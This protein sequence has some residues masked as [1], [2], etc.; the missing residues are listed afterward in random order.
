MPDK[1]VKVLC[2]NSLPANGNAGLKMVMPVL[3]THAIPVPTLLLS[4]IGNMAGYQRFALPFAEL[5]H[6]TLALARDREQP[7]AVYVGYLA[8]DAQA[9]VIAEAI[10]AFRTMIRF[11]LIDPVCGDNGRA[12]VPPAVIESWQ[13]LLPL[14][15]LA[16]PNL[17]EAALL[18]GLQPP[19]D[20][21]DPD[22][23]ISTF[24]QKYPT[25]TT[26]ITGIV[27]GETVTNR[28]IQADDSGPKTFSHRY[29][30]AYFSGTGDT[31]ASLL[32]R[33]HCVENWPLPDAVR[34]AGAV[35]ERLIEQAIAT[36]SGDLLLADR[37]LSNPSII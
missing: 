12:Y 8:D 24:G 20:L 37:F 14:A 16:L 13:T 21:T 11:V 36:G 27:A 17:T 10:R 22:L 23:I 34:Q 4:G 26:V 32:I 1:S 25:L 29:F 6:A 15:N 35:L 3:G 9:A 28:L 18:A 31:F 19:F 30:P 2:I 7:V 5:L 33:L